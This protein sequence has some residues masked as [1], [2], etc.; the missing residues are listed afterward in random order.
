MDELEQ[1]ELLRQQQQSAAA[2]DLIDQQK[3]LSTRQKMAMMLMSQN[4]QPQGQMVSGQYVAPN[5]A[6]QLTPVIN[7]VAG[8]YIANKADDDAAKIAKQMRLGK[9]QAEQGVIDAMSPTPEK[10]TELAGPAYKGQAPMAYQEAKG[11][12]LARAL[13]ATVN[14][15]GAGKELRASILKQ[16]EP[17]TLEKEWRAAKEQGYSGSL[18]D[19]KNMMTDYQ[20][21]S[22]K[23][24]GAR[25]HNESLRMADEGIIG[26]GGGASVGGPAVGGAPV[27]GGAPVVGGGQPVQG[28]APMPAQA[29]TGPTAPPVAYQYDPR[30]TP[31]KNREMLAEAQTQANEA[32]FTKYKAAVD[33]ADIVKQAAALLPKSTSGGLNEDIK[34]AKAYFGMPTATSPQDAQLKV[35]SAKLVASVPRFK[36]AD[37]DKDVAQYMAAAGDVANTRLPWTDRMASLRQI[38]DLNKKY[39]PD[40]YAGMDPDKLFAAQVQ[41]RPKLS[42]S[43]RVIKD[44]FTTT[45]GFRRIP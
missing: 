3:G 36:G 40:S 6:Q 34:G 31:K 1:L 4:Q 38:Y 30:L 37:S 18:L 45:A 27:R 22:L 5:W 9:M 32:Q 39:A 2:E 44:Q 13:K 14:P 15:Y 19:F 33:T 29:M 21:A 12:D 17:T 35:L 20:R 11:P 8:A 28:G 26:G 23:N 25:L 42:E 10:Y 16:M 43:G 24:E 7:Q 41:E